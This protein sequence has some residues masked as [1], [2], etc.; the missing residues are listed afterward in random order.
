[1]PGR[2][3]IDPESIEWFIED[4]DFSPS[5][6]LA[7]PH[8]PPPVSKF[9]SFLVFLCVAVRGVGGGAKTY[10]GEEAW[11]SINH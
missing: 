4:K 9:L 10:N 1:M 8:Y 6:D 7:S 2:I 3:D 5:Y 11:F